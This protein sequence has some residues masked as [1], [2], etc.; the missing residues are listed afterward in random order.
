MKAQVLYFS[1]KD[2]AT[3]IGDGIARHLKCKQD[4]IPPA[5]PAENEKIVF[6]GYDYA[7][8]NNKKFMDF[9]RTMTTAR[10]AN[11][12]FFVVSKTGSGS[13]IAPYKKAIAD[14]GVNVIDEVFECQG[15]FLFSGK[16]K[17]DHN[18]VNNA[19]AWADKVID[20]IMQ[21]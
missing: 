4:A 10:A 7:G 19:I 12:A 2:N 15:K 1:K 21:K 11:V 18:D 14:N 16:G 20:S 9:C 17:P 6:V 8:T 13:D 5:Y 3:M